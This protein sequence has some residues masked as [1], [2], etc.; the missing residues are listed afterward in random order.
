MKETA[1]QDAATLLAFYER[2]LDIEIR[3]HQSRC[4]AYMLETVRLAS[5]ISILKSKL[6]LSGPIQ[7]EPNDESL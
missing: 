1:T 6:G 5:L 3:N 2:S 4:D 7:V